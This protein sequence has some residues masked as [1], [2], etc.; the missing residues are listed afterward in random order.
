[1]PSMMES[2]SSLLARNTATNVPAEITPVAYSEEAAVANPQLGSNPNSVP[3]RGLILL[4]LSR[5][6]SILCSVWFS[7]H[8]RKR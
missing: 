6:L 4:C 1:M 2:I 5:N 7:I 3:A 8:S